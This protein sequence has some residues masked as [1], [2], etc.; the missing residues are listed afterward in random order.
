MSEI[1]MDMLP[2]MRH[3]YDEPRNCAM[4]NFAAL[5]GLFA[6]YRA[7]GGL[8]TGAIALSFG[9]S[10]QGVLLAPESQSSAPT[11]L[12]AAVQAPPAAPT[13]PKLPPLS[14]TSGTDGRNITYNGSFALTRLVLDL[15]QEDSNGR[16]GGLVGSSTAPLVN[17]VPQRQGIA[18]GYG[19]A[20]PQGGFG[21]VGRSAPSV[22][23]PETW[24]LIMLGG[25]M[26]SFMARRK[27]AAD[28]A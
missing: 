25:V 28:N 4:M 18:L 7:A 9:F 6:R 14:Y 17:G 27:K 24:A 11:A 26:A 10:E 2:K 23:E 21:G 20:A 5:L 13:L 3:I 1:P 19:G 16:P 15:P 8:A 22:P 12:V